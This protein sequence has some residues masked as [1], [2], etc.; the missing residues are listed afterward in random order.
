MERMTD[1]S[2]PNAFAAKLRELR[3]NAGYT[4]EQLA[5]IAGLAPNAISALERGERRNPYA[6]T[7]GVLADALKLTGPQRAELFAARPRRGEAR[8]QQRRGTP[9]PLESTPLLGR[10][11]DID[12]ALTMLRR[13]NLRLL[14]LTGPGGVGKTRMSL[15]IA[16]GLE[17]ECDNGVWFVP[18]APVVD[19]ALVLET[20]AYTLGLRSEIE[21]N[22]ESQII[23]TIGSGKVLL[24]LDNFEQV[25]EAGPVIA[26]LLKYC[27]NLRVLVSSRVPLHVA[28]EH[29]LPVRPLPFPRLGVTG[30]LTDLANIPSVQLFLQRAEA[31][32][33]GF[34]LTP[35]NA[36]IISELCARLDG[37]PLAI[38]LAA[39]WVRMLP[40]ADLL[41]Q[42]SDRFELLSGGGPDLPA[43]HQAMREAIDWSYNLLAPED[44][45]HFRALSI[46]A[47]GLPMEGAIAIASAAT[48]ALS[49]FA[50]ISGIARL[51][52]HNLLLREDPTG[53]SVRVGM[54]ETIRE[55]ARD[56]LRASGEEDAIRNAHA[57]FCLE[58]AT[59]ARLDLEGAGRSAAHGRMQ[60]DFDNIRLALGWLIESGDAERACRLASEVARFWTNFGY[61]VE[62]R[63]WLARVLAMPGEVSP[64]TRFD[65]VYWASIMS[66][67][68]DDLDR[69]RNLAHTA[70][71][72]ARSSGNRL[73]QGMAFSHLGELTA[74]EDAEAAIALIDRSMDLFRELGDPFRLATSHRQLGQISYQLGRY[75]LATEQH[76]AALQLWKGMNHPWGIPISWRSLGDISLATGD[77]ATARTQYT[78][79]LGRWMELGERLPVSNCLAGLA[80]AELRLGNHREAVYLLGALDALD[81]EMGFATFQDY[82]RELR[83]LARHMAEG[84]PFDEIWEEG[85]SVSID[86]VVARVIS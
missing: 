40:P 63:A 64:E 43:R 76:M 6:S 51:V 65:A 68:Q 61:L 86:D 79:S 53:G 41:D 9:L 50:S 55:Y 11:S 5:E 38:E 67:L 48:P 29:V 54:L 72:L 12:V 69:A 16:A 33:P 36:G 2:P 44:Q 27:S 74:Y 71:E 35:V 80:E 47:G 60:R 45:S 8:P 75:Q 49:R 1:E 17:P 18:L 39:A 28:G 85:Q 26:N 21:G 56:A 57:A 78:E 37:L 31:V 42:L 58:Y 19:P 81:R 84:L 46:Q 82:R 13:D 77:F 7:V 70:L 22:H 14:T 30:T 59:T 66:S 83:D 62:G 10:D 32:H 52:D 24:V 20:I 15:R 4:Q 34:V 25:V 23:Q 3:R 73:G